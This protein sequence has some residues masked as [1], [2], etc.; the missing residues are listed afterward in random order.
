MKTIEN[1]K[2]RDM[3]L[4]IGKKAVKEAQARSL[5][6]GVPNVFSRDGVP[7][8]QMP[9]GEITSTIPKEYKGVFS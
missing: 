8:F 9:S 6:N 5:A 4:K 2:F 1:Y 3:I 7:Y